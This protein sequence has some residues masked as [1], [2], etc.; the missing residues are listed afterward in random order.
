MPVSTKCSFLTFI[1]GHKHQL[2]LDCN[3][4]SSGVYRGVG[5]SII[6]M[7]HCTA[8]LFFVRQK[9][10]N[11]VVRLTGQQRCT[12]SSCSGHGWRRFVCLM[13]TTD[14]VRWTSDLLHSLTRN[15]VTNTITDYST[16]RTLQNFKVVFLNS[17]SIGSICCGFVAGTAI[18]C[19][20][21]VRQIHDK[22]NRW[23]LTLKT[24]S[25]RRRRQV[26]S[27]R[28]VWIESA[29]VCRDL[30]KS[31]QWNSKKGAAILTPPSTLYTQLNLLNVY[32]FVFSSSTGL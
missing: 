30:E 13:S 2:E 10:E 5:L 32:L 28:S 14:V 11:L 15:A 26:S 19:T 27:R 23:S 8:G 29:T 3:D 12:S 20:T 21:S 31:E 6:S 17:N 4:Y 16:K 22:S 24:I 25:H 7:A 18:C 1:T 9:R